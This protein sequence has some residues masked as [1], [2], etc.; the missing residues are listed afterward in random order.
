MSP[1]LPRSPGRIRACPF[2]MLAVLGLF[3]STAFATTPSPPASTIPCGITLVGTQA[4][5]ADPFGQFAVVVRDLAS[6]PIPGSTVVID[7]QDCEIDI[8][9]CGS[10][11]HAGTTVDCTGP[12]GT[13]S[14][15]TDA[16]GT[17]LLRIVGAARNTVNGWPAET[18]ACARVYADGML[19]GNLSVATLDQDGHGGVNP[20]DLSLWLD[21]LFTG[22][23]RARSDYNCSSSISPADLSIWLG[24]YFAGGSTVSCA[25]FC[26]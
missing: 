9:V 8:R 21:D 14:A 26:H 23:P 25:S 10:Q 13:V 24:A 15:L 11:P 3:A 2:A 18:G 6:N 20:A 4:G 1:T 17:V 7:F 16:T 5:V 22:M 12:V 19:L